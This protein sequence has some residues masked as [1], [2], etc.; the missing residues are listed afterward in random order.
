M[1]DVVSLFQVKVS[2][3]PAAASEP[4]CLSTNLMNASTYTYRP[5]I[6]RCCTE[7]T[8][9]LFSVKVSDLPPL[10]RRYASAIAFLR[11]SITFRL[12]QI[13][14]SLT[15]SRNTGSLFTS[16]SHPLVA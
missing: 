12:A 9:G 5:S 3:V 16:S 2:A 8:N 14:S 13:P 4:Q 1:A 10:D 15:P 7:Y 11:T 6:R